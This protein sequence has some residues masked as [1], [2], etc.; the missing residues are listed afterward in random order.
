M[1]T[2]AAEI[3]AQ[4]VRELEY[5]F[6]ACLSDCCSA[7]ILMLAT[8]IPSYRETHC[9]IHISSTKLWNSTGQWQPR[10]HFTKGL[11]HSVDSGASE[12]IAKEE[13]ERSSCGKGSSDTEE[14]ACT[15]CTAESDELDV[16]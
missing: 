2:A 14:E 13:A 3:S 5:Q 15:N 10:S 7:C 9:P 16:T 6:Y 12:S 8:H 1:T 4:R 11:H